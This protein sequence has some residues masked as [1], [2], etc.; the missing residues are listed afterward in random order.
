MGIVGSINGAHFLAKPRHSSST[1]P[2][3]MAPEKRSI[4]QNRHRFQR[5]GFSYERLIK[6]FFASNAGL[7]IVILILIIVFLLKEGLGFFPGYRRELETYRIAGLE[8]VD[9]SRKNLTAHEQLTSLLNRAYFAEINGKSVRE[10]RRTQEA[11]ALFNAFTDQIAPTRDLILNNPQGETDGNSGMLAILQTNFEKQRANA[12]EK[13][14][15]TP[16]LTADE[17][18]QLIDSLRT[19]R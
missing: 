5:Q 19:R 4:P 6:Y 17:R 1:S 8:F 16:H 11:S 18:K 7:T 12:L 14:L 13:P 10:M 3:T 9:I 2:G 15:P